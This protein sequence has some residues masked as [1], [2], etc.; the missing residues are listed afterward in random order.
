MDVEDL[1]SKEIKLVGEK[2]LKS[3]I[4]GSQHKGYGKLLV[5]TAEEIIKCNG[6]K[7]SSVIAGVG[8]RE[9][10]KNKCG[11]K[12]DGTYDKRSYI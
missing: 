4:E 3:I 8:T 10:Y 7:K 11:Y 1:Y 12:L 9:Y 2:K 5:S 6:L